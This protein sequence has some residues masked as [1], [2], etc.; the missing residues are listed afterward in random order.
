[1]MKDFLDRVLSRKFLV[2]IGI[3]LGIFFTGKEAEVATLMERVADLI[4]AGAVVIGYEFANVM[5]KGKE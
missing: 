2:T 5:E 1:M 4:A 3:I